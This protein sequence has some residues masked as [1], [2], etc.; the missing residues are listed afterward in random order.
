MVIV[1]WIVFALLIGVWANSINRSGIIWGL[2]SLIISP[3]ITGII[4]LIAGS[5]HPNCPVCKEVVKAGALVCKHC[6]Q[7]FK[8]STS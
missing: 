2:V 6:G 3:L 5:N 4:L 8:K 7:T 1:L